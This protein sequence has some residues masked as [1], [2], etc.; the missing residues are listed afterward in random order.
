LWER[1]G[2]DITEFPHLKRWLDTVL[3]RPAVQRGLA[4]GAEK[5]DP[6][7]QRM[8]DPKVQEILFGNKPKG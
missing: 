4:V 5:R 3:A 2:Q 7:G 6:S 1:Q 8:Q